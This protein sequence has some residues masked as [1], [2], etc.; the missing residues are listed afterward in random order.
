MVLGDGGRRQ[1]EAGEINVPVSRQRRSDSWPEKCPSM[2]TVQ[3]STPQIETASSIPSIKPTSIAVANPYRPPEGHVLRCG[4]YY[5]CAEALLDDA[6]PTHAQYRNLTYDWSR[7][8]QI[9]PSLVPPKSV[10]PRHLS[11]ALFASASDLGHT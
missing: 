8:S 7:P 2:A 1:M 11:G 6:Y 10:P 5:T 3:G 4:V 9:I